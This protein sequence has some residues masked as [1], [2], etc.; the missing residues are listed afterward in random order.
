MPELLNF[1]MSNDEMHVVSVL[2]KI[3]DMLWVELLSV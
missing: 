1:K 3:N 2:C